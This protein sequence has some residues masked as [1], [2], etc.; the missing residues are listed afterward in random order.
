LVIFCFQVFK[1]RTSGLY[2]ANRD[3]KTPR[4]RLGSTPVQDPATRLVQGQ[5][6]AHG[7]ARTGATSLLLRWDIGDFDVF[8]VPDTPELNLQKL[9]SLSG[10]MR[11]LYD[12][13]DSGVLMSGRWPVREFA[14]RPE[15]RRDEA[16]QHPRR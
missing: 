5:E 11:W 14:Q 4:G 16:A 1:E 8:D 15:K 2:L 12:C 10:A 6:A 9:Q 13:V 3:L 7:D